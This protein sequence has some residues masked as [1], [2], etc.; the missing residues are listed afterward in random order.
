MSGAVVVSV[1]ASSGLC[2]G[3]EL[4]ISNAHELS[5][6]DLRGMVPNFEAM[7]RHG[8]KRIKSEAAL[9]AKPGKTALMEVEHVRPS[10]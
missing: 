10:V 9:L 5:D 7:L 6:D 2:P 3:L 8:L 4:S 1:H